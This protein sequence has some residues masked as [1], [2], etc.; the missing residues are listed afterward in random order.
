MEFNFYCFCVYWRLLEGEAFKQTL[1]R[2]RYQ[3]V[4]ADR[5]VILNIGKNE[6]ENRIQMEK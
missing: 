2:V 1:K 6:M 3:N 4:W 5:K